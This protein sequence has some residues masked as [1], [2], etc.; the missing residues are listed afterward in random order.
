MDKVV[1]KRAGHYT[2]H[3]GPGANYF[4]SIY[5]MKYGRKKKNPPH[6]TAQGIVEM[7]NKW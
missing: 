2:L 1:V 4:T 3:L 6:D 5:T 7:H